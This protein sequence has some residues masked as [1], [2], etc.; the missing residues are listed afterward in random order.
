MTLSELWNNE[1]IKENLNTNTPVVR[2]CISHPDSM[3]VYIDA[4]LPLTFYIR[5][6]VANCKQA[7]QNKGSD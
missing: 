6:T 4:T 5:R 1:K 3:C 7:R 2:K